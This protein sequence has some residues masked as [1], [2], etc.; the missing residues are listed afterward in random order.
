MGDMIKGTPVIYKKSRKIKKAQHLVGIKPMT[1]TVVSFNSRLNHFATTCDKN[2][3][4]KNKGL[5]GGCGAAVCGAKLLKSWVQ[6]M[7]GT[8]LFSSLSIPQ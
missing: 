8:G 6:F 1:Y 4:M 3:T 2:A 7:P 5:V